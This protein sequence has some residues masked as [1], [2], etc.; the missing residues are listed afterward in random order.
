MKVNPNEPYIILLTKKKGDQDTHKVWQ[1]NPASDP[2]G[3]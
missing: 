1:K 2:G 3:K